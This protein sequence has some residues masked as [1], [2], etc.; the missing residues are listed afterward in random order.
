MTQRHLPTARRSRLSLE[1]KD[2][3]LGTPMNS[4][5]AT[6][7]PSFDA[8]MNLVPIYRVDTKP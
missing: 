1:V 2:S 8:R 5:F 3:Q 4:F 6:R 7:N